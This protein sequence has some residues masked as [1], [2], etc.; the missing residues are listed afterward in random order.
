MKPSP[1]YVAPIPTVVP[2]QDEYQVVGDTG[3]TALWIVFFIMFISSVIFMW[4]S[5][6]VPVAKRLF[7][8]I[9]TLIT[10]FATLS[11][12]AMATGDGITLIGEDA[13]RN[14]KH[15]IPDTHYTVYREVYWARYVD[16]SLTTP[17]LFL[18]LALLAG[19]NGSNILNAMVADEIM[20]ITGLFAAIATS[21]RAKWG[22]YAMACV[23]YLLIIYNLA[24]SA[25][26]TAAA[27]DAQVGRF[28]TYIAGYTLILWTLYPVVW[29]IGDGARRMSLDAEIVSYA[30]LDVLAKPVFGFW[31]LIAHERMPAS[32]VKL[33]GVWSHGLSGSEGS[34]RVGDDDDET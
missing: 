1:T 5:Y 7:H 3:K 6:R 22:W 13:T 17:L 12:F 30:I 21:E 33:D 26:R 2:D 19:L 27:R 10:V 25:R 20:I 16:W 4:M 14:H 32:G 8:Q 34:L 31:L 29:G 15:D 24:I 28:F 23:A 11:Y 18:D 9:T